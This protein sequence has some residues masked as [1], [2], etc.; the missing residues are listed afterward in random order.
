M[1]RAVH[2]GRHHALRVGLAGGDVLT[3]HDRIGVT[4]GLLTRLRRGTVRRIVIKEAGRRHVLAV[5]AGGGVQFGGITER[6]E[7]GVPPFLVHHRQD[8]IVPAAHILRVRRARRRNLDQTCE[9]QG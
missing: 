2:P 6:I 9:G 4:R 7:T 8:L 5:R 1:A 3:P